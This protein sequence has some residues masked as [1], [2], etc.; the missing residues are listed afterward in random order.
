VI[1]RYGITYVYVG[2]TERRDF[3][4][5]GI[6]KFGGLPPVCTSGDVDVYSAD[7]ITSQTTTTAG[8]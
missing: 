4:A 6:A 1:K 5:A 7:S 8:G 2:P 3:S